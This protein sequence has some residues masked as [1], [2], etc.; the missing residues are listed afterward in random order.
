MTKEQDYFKMAMDSM[1]DDEVE[2]PRVILGP[3]SL[4][5]FATSEA[6][7]HDE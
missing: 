7:S 4:E 2:G 6:S 5:R 1:V 3:L